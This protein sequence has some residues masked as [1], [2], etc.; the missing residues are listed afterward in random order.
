MVSDISERLLYVLSH[1]N[2]RRVALILFLL[3]TSAAFIYQRFT[4]RKRK[5]EESFPEYEQNEEGL[6]PWEVD[7]DDSPKRIAKDAKRYINQHQPR[8]GRW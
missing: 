8:R 5:Q 6:Y 1:V 7:T 2:L 4:R 3:M